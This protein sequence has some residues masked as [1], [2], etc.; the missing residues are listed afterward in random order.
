M[1]PALAQLR[2]LLSGLLRIQPGEGG[3]TAKMFGVLFCVVGFFI[4]A[5]VARDSLFLSR[6]SVDYLPMMYIWVALGVSLQSYLYSK[7]ADRFRRDRLVVVSLAVI[8]VLLLLARQMLSWAGDWLYPLL[9]VFVELAGTLLIIQVW[10]MANDVF[11]TR[12]AKRLFS[13]VGAGGVISAM[14]VGFGVRAVV[15]QVGT[16]NLLLVAGT[17]LLPAM[18]LVWRL[19]VTCRPELVATLT[20]PQRRG[21]SGI[22]FK[23]DWSRFWNNRQLLT[24]A[25]LT[26]VLGFTITLVDYQFKVASRQNF[27]GQEDRLA[28]F[29]GMFWAITGAINCLVQFFLTSRLLERQGILFALLLL[30]LAL[31]GGGLTVLAFPALWSVTLLKGSEAVLRYTINDSS[32]QLL[33][34]PVPSHFR[35]RAKAFID[36]IVR[37][38]SVGLSGAFLAWTLPGFPSATV[39]WIL[40]ALCLSWVLAAGLAHRHYYRSLFASLRTRSFQ[41]RETRAAIPD[42]AATR[43]LKKALQQQD[44]QT[45][46]HALELAANRPVVDWSDELAALLKHP[47]AAVRAQTLEQLGRAGSLK[48]GP[49]VYACLKDDNPRVRAAAIEAYCSIGKDRAIPVVTRFL[50]DREPSVQAAAV[51]GLIRYGGLDGV[52]SAAERLKAMLESSRAMERQMGATVLGEIGV[53]NFYHPLLQLIVDDDMA[54]RLAAIRAAGRIKSPELLPALVYRLAEPGCRNAARDAL[55][56]YGEQAVDVLARVLSNPAEDKS[57]RLSV[58]GILARIGS[59]KAMDVLI[60]HLDEPSQQLRNR[61]LEAVHRL[62]VRSP[63]LRYSREA[64]TSS[65]RRETELLYRSS[66]HRELLPVNSGQLLREALE[67]EHQQAIR[68]L[69]RLLAMLKPVRTV[70]AI[71]NH[72]NNPLPRLQANAVELLDGLLEKP[73]KK[74]L[75]PLFDRSLADQRREVARE[76]FSWREISLDDYLHELLSC[77]NPWVVSCTLWLLAETG[78]TA[79][80]EEVKEATLSEHALVRETALLVLS[81]LDRPGGISKTIQRHLRD[82]DAMVRR[83]AEWLVLQ[84]A[85]GK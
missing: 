73:W 8:L 18:L 17:L 16:E 7:I 11:T 37:Q 57:V 21:A 78:R 80:L 55:A 50:N 9:Y 32:S 82:S 34:L 51:A 43:L 56:N 58:P 70:D 67:Y 66:L 48:N 68:R 33:Y 83:M 39:G 3:K 74:L 76:F 60:Q 5:R 61:L 40:L 72:I 81:R 31:F 36:G 84:P 24:I 45:V 30:P 38:L 14:A 41:L 47:S 20:Q 54:V 27:L 52:L 6:Y 1:E 53:R 2:Q 46:L 71:Y 12:E 19:S 63:H 69:F 77:P 25:G 44:E 64:A 26:L 28:A 65:L 59:Q 79:M 15:K 85:P 29:F 10:T 13:I 42:E 23:S 62:L 75:L 22:R 49:Q 35:G 4:A